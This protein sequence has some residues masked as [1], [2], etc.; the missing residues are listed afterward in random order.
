MVD[1]DANVAAA[2]VAAWGAGGR[3]RAV[4]LLK[5]HSSY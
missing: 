3:W 2:N 4:K 5:F 1:E